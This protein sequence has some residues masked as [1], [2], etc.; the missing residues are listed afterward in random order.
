MKIASES[1]YI[2]YMLKFPLMHIRD[3]QTEDSHLIN[4]HWQMDLTSHLSLLVIKKQNVTSI[5][6]IAFL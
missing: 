5:G 2:L 3:L 4:F 6:D 1:A